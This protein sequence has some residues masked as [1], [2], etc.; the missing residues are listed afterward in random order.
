MAGKRQNDI[1]MVATK[2]D[3]VFNNIADII[4]QEIHHETGIACSRR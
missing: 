2:G 1:D 3:N 4:S